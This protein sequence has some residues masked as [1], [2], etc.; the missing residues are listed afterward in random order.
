MPENNRQPEDSSG[1][2]QWLL[3]SRE[4]KGVSLVKAAEVTR[5]SKSYIDALEREDFA[6]LPAPAYCKGFLRIYAVYLGLSPDEAVLLYDTAVSGINQASRRTN[7]DSPVVEPDHSPQKSN[8]WL[9]PLVLLSIV[10]VLA[11][12]VDTNQRPPL[13]RPTP[14]PITAQNAAQPVPVQT[15]HSSA[16]KA[17]LPKSVPAGRI[18]QPEA[19]VQTTSGVDQQREGLI[20]KLKVNQDSWLNV[21]IDG[22]LSK[23]YDLKAGDLI[24]WKADS[25]ITLD[26]GNAGG[27]EGDL[28]GKPL[29]SFGQPGKKAHAVIKNEGIELQ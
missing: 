27:V 3:R 24:E 9:L 28:N 10:I 12:F 15:S 13:Y 8:R 5:I 19:S 16:Q 20:L 14:K 6:R 29:P 25:V 22:R 23:Q 2:G 26:I 18:E 4:A 17:S 7:V 1:V 11:V 21:D